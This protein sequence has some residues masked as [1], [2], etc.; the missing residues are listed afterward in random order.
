MTSSKG[1]AIVFCCKSACRQHRGSKPKWRSTKFCSLILAFLR[2]RSYESQEGMSFEWPV[3]CLM[4]WGTYKVSYQT[5]AVHC[6]SD[7]WATLIFLYNLVVYGHHSFVPCFNMSSIRLPREAKSTISYAESNVSGD[8]RT[9]HWRLCPCFS[10]VSH[11]REGSGNHERE[12]SRRSNQWTCWWW[13]LP[14]I[15]GFWSNQSWIAWESKANGKRVSKVSLQID[16]VIAYHE[17]IN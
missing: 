7:D 8:E 2:P 6:S 15:P 3:S 17:V 4:P 14:L 10:T 11:G 12:C 16:Q 5:W 9:R 13:Q 1:N